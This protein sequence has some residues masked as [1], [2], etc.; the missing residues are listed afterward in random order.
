MQVRIDYLSERYLPI[1]DIATRTPIMCDS[2]HFTS[3]T[4]T[5]MAEKVC[6]PLAD[7]TVST[8]REVSHTLEQAEDN[9]YEEAI[10]I[11]QRGQN[12]IGC[13]SLS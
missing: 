5:V 6:V 9:G 10:V 11:I 1:Y 8:L 7:L 13:V 2:P 3:H 4:K 12:R